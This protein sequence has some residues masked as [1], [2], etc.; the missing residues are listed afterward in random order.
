MRVDAKQGGLPLS[1]ATVQ[2]VLRTVQEAAAMLG[3]SVYQVRQLIKDGAVR[4]VLIRSAVRIPLED[5]ERI[6]REGTP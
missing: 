5:V 3:L 2:P 1:Q 6:A 4:K